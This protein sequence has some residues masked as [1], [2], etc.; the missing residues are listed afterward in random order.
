[1]AAGDFNNDGNVNLATLVAWSGTVVILLNDGSGQFTSSTIN[2]S[3]GV[4]SRFPEF[5]QPGDFNNDGKTDLVVTNAIGG[6]YTVL[7]N[8]GNAQ[9]TTL[10]SVEQNIPNQSSTI[11]VGDF[12]S[13]GKSDLAITR[14]SSLL[15]SNGHGDGT[16]SNAVVYPMP[17]S[18]SMVRS[19]DLNA[20]GRTDLV[21]TRG[22]KFI[23]G[24]PGMTVL[25][26]NSSGGF[27]R[28]EYPLSAPADDVVIG[29]FDGDTKTDL[30]L[31]DSPTNHATLF[32]RK[33][34][35]RFYCSSPGINHK[36]HFGIGDLA[37]HRRG[38]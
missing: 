34:K 9:F 14:N 19:A 26:A 20:D 36:R 4:P 12:N 32:F 10:P 35:R 6:S 15:V 30:L 5:I 1:M 17:P 25:L 2:T 7:I 13:D 33:R 16:F 31:T 18:A 11:A 29:D 8:N 22:Q 27:T 23:I 21:V 3:F 28:T 38:Y 24:D 37:C